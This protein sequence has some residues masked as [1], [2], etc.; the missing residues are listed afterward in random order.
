M[1]YPAIHGTVPDS[2]GFLHKY[3]ADLSTVFLFSVPS[4]R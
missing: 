3:G 1:E 2:P 4:F